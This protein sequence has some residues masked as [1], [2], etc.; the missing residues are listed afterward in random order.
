MAVP[1]I[2]DCKFRIHGL[3]YRYRGSDK[4]AIEQACFDIKRGSATAILGLSGSGKS[5]LLNILGRLIDYRPSKGE[6]LYAPQHEALVD[7]SALNEAS[8]NLLRLHSFGFVMQASNMLP[9]LT[10]EMNVVMPLLLQ[11][12]SITSA[13]QKLKCLLNELRIHCD[14]T[15]LDDLQV[16]LSR[17]AGEVS[18]GQRQRMAVLRALIHQP[19][20]VFADEPCNSLDPRNVKAFHGLLLGW[21]KQEQ[22]DPHRTLVL[23]THNARE[24]WAIASQFILICGHGMRKVECLSQKDLSGPDELES[25]M[26]ASL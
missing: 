6:I 5:T 23:I 10:C 22:E 26:I 7:Y 25:R 12:H 13:V 3:T 11:G 8:S 19:Q 1:M 21:L 4:D 16:A 17:R 14:G 2:N 20:V 18:G 9:N 15:S 24:A